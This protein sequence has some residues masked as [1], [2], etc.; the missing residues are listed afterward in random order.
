M[1]ENMQSHFEGITDGNDWANHFISIPLYLLNVR[2]TCLFMM[3][4]YMCGDSLIAFK[5]AFLNGFGIYLLY[6]IAIVF[7]DGRPFWVRS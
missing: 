5:G 4:F 2:A 6:L 7:R 3:I 1:I